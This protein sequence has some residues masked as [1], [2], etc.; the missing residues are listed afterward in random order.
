MPADQRYCKPDSRCGAAECGR[1]REIRRPARFNV[2]AALQ[3]ETPAPP[4]A[5]R[6]H[7]ETPRRAG[8]RLAPL[9]IESGVRNVMASGQFAFGEDQARV[10]RTLEDSFPASDP[11]S[12]TASVVRPAPAREALARSA[13]PGPIRKL[14]QRAAAM[15]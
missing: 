3:T 12:W 14:L 13:D 4:D 5:A 1:N 8:S 6:I 10:D 9:V 2:K 11:P 7:E 15:F